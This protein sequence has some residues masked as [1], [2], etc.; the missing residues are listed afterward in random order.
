MVKKLTCWTRPKND[1]GKY[2][3]CK[4]GQKKKKPPAKPAPKKKKKLIIK[5]KAPPI[6]ITENPRDNLIPV[7][8]RGLSY[9]PDKYVPTAR[10]I[11][12]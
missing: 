3:T 2:T 7:K 10:L 12:L 6:T 4:E 1:G 9:V 8:G 5:R 11:K